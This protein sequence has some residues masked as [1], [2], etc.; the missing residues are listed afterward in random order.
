MSPILVPFSFAEGVTDL[1][2]AHIRRYFFSS[3]CL[4]FG[5][6]LLPVCVHVS[7]V[8]EYILKHYIQYMRPQYLQWCLRS[9]IVNVSLQPIHAFTSSSLIHSGS[10]LEM[11]RFGKYEEDPSILLFFG[12][13]M[14]GI[15]NRTAPGASGIVL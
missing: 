13:M 7:N 14:D 15:F 10:P 2:V 1:H 11:N 12:V 8:S 5:A 3:I 4:N 6:H 9:N